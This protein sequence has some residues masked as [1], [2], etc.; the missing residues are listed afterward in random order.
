M[1]R[2]RKQRNRLEEYWKERGFD[3][4]KEFLIYQ[5]LCGSLRGKAK[6][7]KID[8]SKQFTKY[9]SWKEHIEGII[10]AYKGD[11]LSEFYHFIRLR[12]RECD[13]DINISTSLMWPI[14]AAIVSG[15]IA[16]NAIEMLM[17]FAKYKITNW[18]EFMAF[19][20]V[21]IFSVIMV[22]F[23]ITVLFYNTLG[24]YIKPKNK[25]SFWS[26]CLEIIEEQYKKER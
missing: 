19:S 3:G 16:Q 6:I 9:E 21:L 22:F 10:M 23:C 13:I 12:E 11:E 18:I 20:I 4:D 25:A 1:S 5:Y 15:I 24:S 17:S 7:N 14:V 26:D 2:K 8:K